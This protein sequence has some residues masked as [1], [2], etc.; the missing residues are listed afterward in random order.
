M[1][2]AN[3]TLATTRIYNI[4]DN[5]WIT[6]RPMPGVRRG[7]AG[8]Y[9]NGKLYVVG[10]FDSDAVTP[11]SQTWEY[12]IANDTWTTRASLPAAL[13]GAT[14]AVL[15]GHLYVIGGR[16]TANSALSTVYDYNISL[17]SWTQR[18]GLQVAR[19][20]P[21]SAVTKGRIWVFGGGQP[22]LGAGRPE[23][24]GTTEIY[25][26]YR[27]SWMFGPRQTQDRSFQAGRRF[28]TSW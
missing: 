6:A 21:G 20:A 23:T 7:A 27:N 24:V 1:N 2:G 5:T 18:A 14:G 9:Y 3:E 15:G 11:Q 4:T 8:G 25:D 12:D 28:A 16:D 10:G 17:N 13:G 26:P 19:N 22:L